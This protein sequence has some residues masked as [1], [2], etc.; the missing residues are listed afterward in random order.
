MC[1][2]LYGLRTDPGSC[3]SGEPGLRRAAASQE[4]AIQVGTPKR[5]ST[6]FISAK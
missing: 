6:H 4:L 5:G 3:P 2:V 1:K